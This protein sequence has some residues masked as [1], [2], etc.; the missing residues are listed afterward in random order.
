MTS[1]GIR[2][3]ERLAARLALYLSLS[4]T[5]ATALLLLPYLERRMAA[6]DPEWSLRDYTREPAVRELQELIRLDTTAAT[7]REVDLARRLE[8]DLREMGLEPVVE[9]LIEGRANLWATIEGESQKALVLHSHLDTDDV[10]DA[11]AWRHPPFDGAIEGPWIYG[12]GAYDMKSLTVA[13]LWAV[14]AVQERARTTGRRPP[15]SVIFLATGGEETGSEL[16]ARWFVEQHP[17]LVRRF[18]ALL[19]EGGVIEATGQDR[20]KY[21]GISFAQ[22][23]FLRLLACS[24]SRAQLEQLRAALEEHEV[25]RRVLVPETRDFL[26]AYGPSREEL[27]LKDRASRPEIALRGAWTFRFLPPYL[28]A[29]YRNEVHPLAVTADESSGG[30]RLEIVLHLLPGEDPERARRELLPEWITHGVRIVEEEAGPATRGSP[31]DH[32]AFLGLVD[33]VRRRYDTDAVGP[34]FLSFYD[35]DA[36]F[37]RAVG[38]PSYGFSPFVAYA[39]DSFTVGGRNERITLPAFLEGVELYR[40]TV[41]ELVGWSAD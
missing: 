34:Y 41:L 40:D 23:T 37:F 39:P 12:R 25:Y 33:A 10:P 30:Y 3:R 38:V 6:R 22:K 9:E 16:G 17:D 1:S 28:Q 7:G 2:R 5:V 31:L 20:I 14:R 15:R 18:W 11:D 26:T 32:P 35:N 4:L 13:Q 29:L 8:Q 24:P 36:R 19:T 21:W 27:L